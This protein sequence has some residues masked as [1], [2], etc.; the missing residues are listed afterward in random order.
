MGQSISFPHKKFGYAICDRRG[1]GV[2]RYFCDIGFKTKGDRDD[3][4][5][6]ISIA[7]HILYFDYPSIMPK[8]L[9]KIYIYHKITHM[10]IRETTYYE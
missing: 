4:T 2:D 8:S 10:Y 6:K 7:K 1:S 5:H 3:E 9:I